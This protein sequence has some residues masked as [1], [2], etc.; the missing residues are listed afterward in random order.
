MVIA[1][2]KL[3]SSKQS[4]N[5]TIDYL[6]FY[7]PLKNFSCISWAAKFKPMLGVQGL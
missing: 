5:Q 6:R 1:A 7:V 3:K 4:N 2:R